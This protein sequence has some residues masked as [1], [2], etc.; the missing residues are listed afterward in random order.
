MAIESHALLSP[1][2]SED[3]GHYQDSDFQSLPDKNSF[4]LKERDQPAFPAV[5]T[6]LAIV[7]GT[8]LVGTNIGWAYAFAKAASNQPIQN[9]YGARD[10]QTTFHFDWVNLQPGEDESRYADAKWEELFPSGGGRVA[11][12][13]DIVE[14]LSLPASVPAA[15]DP[16]KRIYQIAGY[17]QLHCLDKIRDVLYDVSDLQKGIVRDDANPYLNGSNWDHVLH[18][19]EG[20]R[21]GLACRIDESLLPV[22]ETWPPIGD[23]SGQL[24]TCKNASAL[25]HWAERNKGSE[26]RQWNLDNEH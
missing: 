12:S 24:R 19:V 2:S 10:I 4:T 11:L 8:L 16:E 25:R 1:R 26:N 17:H 13:Q 5:P 14:K 7:L 21:Q 23:G 18:C 20:V 6:I 9:Y 15:Q 3:L 22:K